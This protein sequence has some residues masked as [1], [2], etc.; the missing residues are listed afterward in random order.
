[1]AVVTGGS[2]GI[3]AAVARAFAAAGARVVVAARASAALDEVAREIKGLAVASDVRSEE[4]VQALMERAATLGGIHLVVAAAG[5]GRFSPV[6][7]TSVED[8][9]LVMDVNVRGTF[10]TCRAALPYLL[11]SGGGHIFTLSSVA[12]TTTFAGS[13]AYTVS[14]S[15]VLAFTRVL[16]EEV[17]RRGVKVTAVVPGSV[18]SPFWEAAGG[19]ELPRHEMLSAEHVAQTVLS[20][21]L[22]PPEI[23]TDE[24]KIMPPAGI[25]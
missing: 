17:R 1:M 22:Q 2:R 12:A 3:G 25:L 5:L 9:D 16:T 7:D 13:A 21:A 6:V 24:I 14:K 11:A 15:A 10:L 19:T 4:E 20:L 18:D 8:W 23:Y